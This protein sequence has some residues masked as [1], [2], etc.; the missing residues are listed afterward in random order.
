MDFGELFEDDARFGD[1]EYQDND[2]TN[3]AAEDAKQGEETQEPVIQQKPQPSIITRQQ[4]MQMRQAQ[5][6]QAIIQAVQNK[7]E[8]EEMKLDQKIAN[9]ENVNLTNDEIDEIHG[10][11]MDE[12]KKKAKQKEKW[13]ANAHGSIHELH[14]QKLFFEHVKQSK[15]CICVFYSKNNTFCMTLIEHLT[16]LSRKH[17]ECKFL[18]IEVQKAPFL[19]E[20]LN[21]W[22]TPTLVCATNNKVSRHL[23]G[24]DWCAPDGKI[25]TCV[26]EQRLYE[27]GFFEETYLQMEKQMAKY[28]K[29]SKKGNKNCI[30]Y[31]SDSSDDLLD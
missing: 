29:N 27:F 5:V 2:E 19:M 14:D 17:L 16:L 15:H 7:L 22:M 4:Q 13:L 28:K 26:L 23:R 24:L 11:R 3:V 12:L 25:D 31:A 20:R 21:I 18:Q 8:S 9:L 10:R 1:Q 30:Q 6:K